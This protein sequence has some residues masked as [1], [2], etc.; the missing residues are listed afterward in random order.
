[1]AVPDSG[2]PAAIGFSQQSG[3]PYAEGLI[4]KPLRGPYLYSANPIH[5]RGGDSDEAQP[6]ERRPGWQSG[7]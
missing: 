7:Y 6:L 2:V 5:A 1:M 3:I 4:K